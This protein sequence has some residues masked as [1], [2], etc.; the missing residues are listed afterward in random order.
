MAG[1]VGQ[2]VLLGALQILSKSES[3]R[4]GIFRTLE[5]RNAVGENRHPKPGG[6]LKSLAARNAQENIADTN[7]GP[8]QTRT[9]PDQ[10][11]Q[12]LWDN[13]AIMELRNGSLSMAP[14]ME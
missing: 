8:L 4:A 13:Q 1:G 3:D 10:G 11:R 12:K 7:I 9:C 2:W 6:H 14:W 5:R